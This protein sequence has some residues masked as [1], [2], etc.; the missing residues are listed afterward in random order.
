MVTLA[1]EESFEE[2]ENI[3]IKTLRKE[4]PQKFGKAP[5]EVPMVSS[6]ITSMVQAQTTPAIVKSVGRKIIGTKMLVLTRGGSKEKSG[7]ET[8]EQ[9]LEGI[10]RF[11][12]K[13]KVT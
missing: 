9:L 10:G 2:K 7:G 4:K 5:G 6:T 11:C 12:G 8:R 1:G 3:G 13:W